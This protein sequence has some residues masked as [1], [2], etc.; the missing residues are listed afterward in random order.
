[1]AG[2]TKT[3]SGDFAG[4]IAGKIWNVIKEI[5]EEKKA[6]ENQ[7]SKDVKDAAKKLSKDDKDSVPVKDKDLRD[8]VANI[9]LPLEVKLSKASSNVDGMSAKI[10]AIGGSISDTQKLVINQ[11]EILEDKLDTMLGVLVRRN[12]TLDK[13]RE[14]KIY[15][16]LE[17]ALEDG[18]DV[19]GFGDIEKT[20]GGGGGVMANLMWGIFKDIAIKGSV[21]GRFIKGQGWRSIKTGWLRK[22]L[23]KFFRV[24]KITSR[25]LTTA[26]RILPPHVLGKILGATMMTPELGRKIAKEYAPGGV[27]PAMK[28]LAKTRGLELL[29]TQKVWSKN[30]KPWTTSDGVA[31]L[32]RVIA[33]ETSDEALENVAKEGGKKALKKGGKRAAIKASTK[34]WQTRIQGSILGAFFSSPKAQ[35]L[36]V[37]KLGKE[38]V[39]ELGVKAAKGVVKGGVP[40][41]GTAIGAVEGIARLLMGDPKGMLLSFGSSIPVAGWGFTILD[42]LRDIDKD[43]YES[44][45]E[46]NFPFP[47]DTD[48]ARYFMDAVGITPDQLERGTGHVAPANVGLGSIQEIVGATLAIGQAA[49]IDTK[50]LVSDAG[51]G[52][53]KPKGTYNFDISPT[54]GGKTIATQ[55]KM[56][57]DRELPKIKKLKK[58]DDEEEVSTEEQIKIWEKMSKTGKLPEGGSGSGGNLIASHS[59][60]VPHG[61]PTVR[62]DASGEP[63]VDFT[64]D[65]AYNRAVFDGVVTEIGHQYNPNVIGGD[66][67]MGAGYGHYI[68]VTGTDPATGEKFDAVYAHFPEGELN[69]WKLG[70]T[71]N[72]GDVLGLMGTSADYANPETRKHVGSGTG[73]HTSLDFFKPGSTAAYPQWRGLVDRIDPS[74]TPKPALGPPPPLPPIDN[75]SAVTSNQTNLVDKGSS[76]RLIAKRKASFSSP[77]IMVNNNV[78]TATAS[79]IIVSS[80]GSEFSVKDIQYARLAT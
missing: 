17:L 15:Q 20:S 8:T 55:T 24:K 78:M 11:N 58:G 31:A 67:R 77:V 3:Y 72:Y 71:V 49:G 76:E 4:F 1:M 21:K 41:I 69:R 6:E 13:L 73:P 22:N 12:D 45:I 2:L 25:A 74:F 60:L 28:H 7:A 44:H 61:H 62:I 35:K 59:S 18:I 29:P 33:G 27:S 64:P 32:N 40:L 57:E 43:S 79:P 65:G 38:A 50:T 56:V 47:S 5:D 51:L 19:A 75:I 30:V 9:F 42:I 66:G 23:L 53:V 36:L 14:D 48:F 37:S 52:S 46:P 70:D 26:A 80:G 16:Q 34:K 68:A 63:G 10:T 54:G 39:E